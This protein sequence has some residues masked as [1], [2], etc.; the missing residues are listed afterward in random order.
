M[1]TREA[2]KTRLEYL[3]KRNG[4]DAQG[5]AAVRNFPPQPDAQELKIKRRLEADLEGYSVERSAGLV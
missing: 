4:L 2:R 5:R 3:Q 1:H